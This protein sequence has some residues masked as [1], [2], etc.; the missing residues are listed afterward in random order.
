MLEFITDV[1]ATARAVD[2]LDSAAEI[3]SEIEAGGSWNR[4][5]FSEN[6]KTAACARIRLH[7]SLRSK[8]EFEANRRSAR[9]IV[10]FSGAADSKRA[11]RSLR[12]NQAFHTQHR[13]RRHIDGPFKCNCFVGGENSSVAKGNIPESD[14]SRRT[15]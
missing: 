9:G 12:K 7:A 8:I 2:D 3:K 1:E 4:N 11:R 10:S 6:Q 15:N 14:I 5:L 13:D